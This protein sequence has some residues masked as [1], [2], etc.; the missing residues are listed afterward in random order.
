MLY[1]ENWDRES[2]VCEI[3]CVTLRWKDGGSVIIMCGSFPHKPNTWM[4]LAS[5]PSLREGLGTRLESNQPWHVSVAIWLETEALEWMNESSEDSVNALGWWECWFVRF[6]GR[7]SV[8]DH[9]LIHFQPQLFSS[10]LPWGC[11][12]HRPCSLFSP[13]YLTY[14][15]LFRAPSPHAF[16][17]TTLKSWVELGDEASLYLCI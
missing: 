13:P 11:G 3:M 12:L 1:A 4:K 14:H 8:K 5:S 17:H 2:L 16:Q 9:G 6:L 7:S 10:D 15:T